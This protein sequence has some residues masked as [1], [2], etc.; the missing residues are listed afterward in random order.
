[1]RGSSAAGAAGGEGRN[2]FY[3]LQGGF[4]TKLGPA[5]Q[6]VRIKGADPHS[7]ACLGSHRD[8]PLF[9]AP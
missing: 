6:G 9:T 5:S 4:C 1:M 7:G 8:A 3:W 2:L